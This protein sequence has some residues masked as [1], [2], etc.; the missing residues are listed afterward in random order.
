M[1]SQVPDTLGPNCLETVVRECVMPIHRLTQ[2]LQRDS[3]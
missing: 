2:K 1:F 3:V